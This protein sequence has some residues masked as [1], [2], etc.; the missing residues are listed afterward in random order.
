MKNKVPSLRVFRAVLAILLCH[1][2]CPSAGAAAIPDRRTEACIVQAAARHGVDP[3]LLAAVA[4]TESAFNPVAINRNGNGTEDYGLMQ[5]NGIWSAELARYGINRQ[6]M[7][8][9][10]VSA[11]VGA[12]ILSG[13]IRTHGDVWKGVSAYNTGSPSRGMGYAAKV[14]ANR[15]ALIADMAKARS[16]IQ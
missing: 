10:C 8:D 16:K 9:P 6:S 4:R 2:A 15:D 13:Y 1:L 11:H 7:A 3:W 14:K 5:V 12:W